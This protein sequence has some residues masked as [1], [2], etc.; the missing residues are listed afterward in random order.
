MKY[1]AFAIMCSLQLSACGYAPLY[2]SPP[3]EHFS[4]ALVGAHTGDAITSDEVAAG[5]RDALAKEGALAPGSTYPRVEIEV[6]RVDETSEGIAAVDA[7]GGHVPRARATEVG[8]VARA[9]IARD[10]SGSREADTG[11]LRSLDLA[12]APN[13]G[14]SLSAEA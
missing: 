14:D 13:E 3:A 12:A 6:L 5:V 1:G 7:P 11:D 9:W 4:V 8:I 2:A 10:A